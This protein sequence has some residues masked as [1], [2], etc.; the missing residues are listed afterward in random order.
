V[1]NNILKK[2]LRP[3]NKYLR[4]LR[5][6]YK[7]DQWLFNFHTFKILQKIDGTTNI[8]TFLKEKDRFN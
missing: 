7:Y 1:K 6:K 8:D 3:I 5:K 4:P 2:F